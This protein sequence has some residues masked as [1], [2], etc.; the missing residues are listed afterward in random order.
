PAHRLT[1]GSVR[2]RRGAPVGRGPGAGLVLA[3]ERPTAGRSGTPAVI[4]RPATTVVGRITRLIDDAHGLHRLLGVR[5]RRCRLRGAA[6]DGSRRHA[7]QRDCGET[8]R[9][10]AKLHGTLLGSTGNEEKHWR[11][12]PPFRPP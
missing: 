9:G 6:R 5:E 12:P 8:A 2:L 11:S 10:A 3:V 7:G 1:P 4:P